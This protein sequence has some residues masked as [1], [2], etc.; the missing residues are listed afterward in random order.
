MEAGRFNPLLNSF[1]V[2][3]FV[4]EVPTCDPRGDSFTNEIGELLMALLQLQLCERR[5]NLLRDFRGATVFCPSVRAWTS[6][7]ECLP[8]HRC[9]CGFTFLFEWLPSIAAFM[10]SVFTSSLTV[11][12]SIAAFMASLPLRP[13]A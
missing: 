11:C 4:S 10:A 13:S 5:T 6:T 1:E 12:P 2:V 9:F 7:F 3:R 8:E